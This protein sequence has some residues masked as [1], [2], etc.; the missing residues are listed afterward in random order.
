MPYEHD[1]RDH[2]RGRAEWSNFPTTSAVQSVGM[3]QNLGHLAAGITA[4]L[5]AL[6]ASGCAGV[7]RD[8]AQPP[9][10]TEQTASQAPASPAAPTHTQME[11]SRALSRLP[12]GWSDLPPPPEPRA[13]ATSLWIDTHLFYWGGDSD[14][15]GEFH[16]EGWLFDPVSQR[17][18]EIAP[19]PLSGR[20]GTAAVWTGREVIL[21]GGYDGRGVADGETAFGDGAAYD[22]TTDRWR[23]LPTAPIS[24]RPPAA[25]VWTGSEM[26]LWGSVGRDV[27]DA[28][29]DGA[30]FDPETNTWR[31]VPAAPFALNQADAVWTG[32]EML[33]F[34][35]LLNNNNASTTPTSVGLAYDP[36]SETWR[37]LP[38]ARLSPQASAVAWTGRVMIAWDYELKAQA[39]DPALDAWR[40]LPDLPLDFAECYPRSAATGRYVF[41]QYCGVHTFWDT[42]TEAWMKV[43]EDPNLFGEVVAAGKVFLFAG[44][45]HESVRNRLVA[46]KPSG[47]E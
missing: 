16:A 32:Q 15:S 18:H 4:A 8:S 25:T 34:G 38:T 1:H 5:L 6:I 7:F 11:A 33:V 46:F 10:Q 44:A 27:P 28:P 42:A 35:S 36:S 45:A 2:E 12:A 20:S 13:R 3:I 39:Y 29:R 9:P 47:P 22:P 17:W 24:A 21:W 43:T 30:A 23:L 19:S 40:P 41:A 14:Y 31:E 26:I 37:K